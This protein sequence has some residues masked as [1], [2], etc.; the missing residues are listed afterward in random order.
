M[1]RTGQQ[2]EFEDCG[3][4]CLCQWGWNWLCSQ[5]LWPLVPALLPSGASCFHLR[6]LRR[7]TAAAT[8]S[9]S[10]QTSC[11][12]TGPLTSEWKLIIQLTFCLHY[13]YTHEK[14]SMTWCYYSWCYVSVTSASSQSP[15]ASC[16]PKEK[17]ALSMERML[18]ENGWTE[19][20]VTC[21]NQLS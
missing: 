4:D 5:Q 3:W 13:I 11:Q 9:S 8:P 14:A 20:K 15:L 21:E 18:S 10:L 19:E 2:L 17:A 1:V 16:G 6:Q 7:E 12:S